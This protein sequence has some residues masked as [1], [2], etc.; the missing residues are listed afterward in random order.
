[1]KNNTAPGTIAPLK[2]PE[3]FGFLTFST[4][5]GLED[6]LSSVPAPERESYAALH[7]AINRLPERLR[8]TVILFYFRDMDLTSAARVL[9]IP[10]GTMKSRLNHARKKLKEA[11]EHETDLPF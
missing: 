6:A 10:P 4:A 3:K 1:M 9:N 11:L 8:M 5:E 7:A 2:F